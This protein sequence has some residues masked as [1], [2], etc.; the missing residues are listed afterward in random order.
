MEVDE[1]TVLTMC[2]I[3]SKAS[4]RDIIPV[5]NFHEEVLIITENLNFELISLLIRSLLKNKTSKE[6]SLENL[7]YEYT[8]KCQFEI[9]MVPLEDD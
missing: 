9:S 1:R 7:I 3:I 2:E 5:S 6:K 4:P 8:T